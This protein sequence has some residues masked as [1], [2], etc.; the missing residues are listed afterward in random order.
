MSGTVGTAARAALMTLGLLISV[1]LVA[2]CVSVLDLNDYAGAAT[3]LCDHLTQCF[4]T[5]DYEGCVDHV[6]GGLETASPE[7]RSTW[8]G[9]IL[10]EECLAKCSAGK[11]CLDSDPI[12]NR[13]G[14]PCQENS[15][16][17]GFLDNTR[18][19]A[20]G[21]C[22]LGDGQSCDASSEC[23]NG[24]DAETGTCGGAVP[25]QPQGE[26]CVDNE[27]CCSGNCLDE[28]IC[29]FICRDLNEDCAENG[30]CCSGL[31]ENSRCVCRGDQ[32]SC[33]ESAECCSGLCLGG[34]CIAT[35]DCLLPNESCGSSNMPCCQLD[36]LVEG[37]LE[38]FAAEDRCCIPNGEAL[39]AGL[40]DGASEL[41]CS[42]SA[43]GGLCCNG[44]G[45]G[46]VTNE[47]CCT[48]L[49]C[50]DLPGGDDAVCCNSPECG[51]I[52]EPHDQPVQLAGCG[53]VSNSV[54]QCAQAICVLRPSCC[55]EDW[56]II[57]AAMANG[58]DGNANGPAIC[59]DV[60]ASASNP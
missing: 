21:R 59:A 27:D 35:D 49:A 18:A 15:Y 31:C 44:L 48:G 50:L 19:C 41:C 1:T 5:E 39:G 52:C 38:C 24:C 56:D 58:G 57:C 3:T 16:C 29:G 7:A 11:S 9:S 42:R 45:G 36:N 23:C 43:E 13:D 54:L 53:N 8:L 51:S 14:D 25:C 46:C 34:E 26:V 37:T 12:C 6:S 2:S 20:D 33:N 60:C 10:D 17:C 22:C 4:G 55:C 32:A 28:G 47:N 40:G 30:E